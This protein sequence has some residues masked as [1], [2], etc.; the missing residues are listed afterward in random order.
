MIFDRISNIKKYKEIPLDVAD[1]VLSLTP[2]TYPGH[3]EISGD[4]YANIDCYVTKPEEQGKLESHKKYIDIQLLLTGEERLDY[5]DISEL[6]VSESY[7]PEKD[8]MFYQKTDKFLNSVKLSAGYFVLLYP[9]EAHQP[10]MSLST[11]QSVKKVVVKIP[12]QS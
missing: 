4:T 2:E 5:I 8:I 1:F 11:P 9:A 6:T 7:N 3:Y 12:F 10:Q